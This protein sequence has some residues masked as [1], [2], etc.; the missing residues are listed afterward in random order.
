MGHGTADS[1]QLTPRS[2]FYDRGRFGRLFPTLPPFAADTPMIRDALAE[3]GAPGGP[4]DA[5]DDLSDPVTL[6]TVPAKSTHN[7]D[8]PMMTAGFTFL[9]QFLDHDMTFDPTSSLARRQDPESI[10]NFRIPAL[11]LDSVYGGG[12]GAS[13]HL[14]NRAVDGGRT[15][16][17]T[18][19]IPGSGAVSID[20]NARRDLPRNSQ[21]VALTGDPRT[22]RTWSSPSCIW[23]S[24]ASTT[25]WWPTSKPSWGLATPPTRSSPRR[26]GQ[27]AGTTSGSSCT[28]SCPRRSGRPR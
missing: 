9:G 28:S 8:N 23:P 16:L 27:C 20:G 10:R 4:M 21:L 14:Y 1:G 24:C 22:T 25:P 12:P 2:S 11:D 17:L 18:E 15:T 6:I 19:R 5:G 7:P 3:L 13:A 26:S